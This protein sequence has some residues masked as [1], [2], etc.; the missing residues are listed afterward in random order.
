M[1]HKRN[2]FRRLCRFFLY[3]FII[4]LILSAILVG[5]ARAFTPVLNQYRDK[6]TAFASA[7]LH[8]SVSV[9]RVKGSWHWLEPMIN[10][11]DIVVESPTSSYQKISIQEMDVGINLMRSLFH[12]RLEWGS[13]SIKGSSLLIK[14]DVDEQWQVNGF[15]V[16]YSKSG[17]SLND[18]LNQLFQIDRID[19]NDINLQIQPQSGI[20]I[21][22]NHI[23]LG[24]FNFG[25]RHFLKGN[26]DFV[27]LST[28]P[29]AFILRLEHPSADQWKI[30][31]RHFQIDRLGILMVE[32]NTSF[33]WS[34]QDSQHFMVKGYIDHIALPHLTPLLHLDY[35]FPPVLMDAWNTM[36]PQ[37]NLQDLSWQVIKKDNAPLLYNVKTNIEE[38][39]VNPWKKF[40]GIN[41]L[42]GHVE[43]NQEKGSATLQGQ[44]SI[45]AFPLVFRHPLPVLSWS[46]I[47]N[48]DNQKQGLLLSTSNAQLSTVEGDAKAQLSIFVPYNHD[49]SV[50]NLQAQAHANALSKQAIYGY[51]PT[52]ILSKPLVAWL[53]ADLLGVGDSR[54]SV[55]LKGPLREFPFD[56]GNGAFIIQGDV[57]QAALQLSPGWPTAHHLT[58]HLLFSG[59][60]MSIQASSGEINGA[61]LTKADAEIPY[62]GNQ[63]P[64]V[65]HVSA[66]GQGDASQAL[67][68]LRQSP[69]QHVFQGA[70]KNLEADGPIGLDLSLDLPLSPVNNITPSVKGTLN[71]Q[72]VNL[73]FPSW[74]FIL[75]DLQ[76]TAQFNQQ[77]VTAPKIVGTAFGQA[78]T[79]AISPP[80]ATNQQQT[81]IG[82][83]TV[84][85]LSA[86]QTQYNW[87]FNAMATGTSPITL[88]LEIGKNRA[89]NFFVHSNL[90]GITLNL[91]LS[92]KKAA[93]QSVPTVLKGNYLAPTLQALSFQYGKQLSGQLQPDNRFMLTL[94]LPDIQGSVSLPLQWQPGQML[95][96]QMQRLYIAANAMSSTVSSTT[97]DPTRL[98]KVTYSLA[99]FRY[100]NYVLGQLNGTIMPIQNGA[101]IDTQVSQ[102]AAL[103]GQLKT[104]WLAPA[105]TTMTGSLA[106]SDVAKAL[107]NM[108]L[109]SNIQSQH[110][111]ADFVLNWNGAPYQCHIAALNG[112]INVQIND[113]LITGLNGD[114]NAKLGFG[115]ILTSLSL[116]NLPDRL[117][118]VFSGSVQ[119]GFNFT[120]INASVQVK[121]GIATV[122]NG[123]VVSSLA[124]ISMSGNLNLIDQTYDMIMTVTPHVTSS[125]PVAATLVGGPVVGV[126]VWAANKVLSPVFN[127]ITSYRYSITGSF[128]K[129]V[130]T[131]LN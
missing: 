96:I 64:V 41:H 91:P 111:T 46:G 73:T 115:R 127:A 26:A 33:A 69:Y 90:Q 49:S 45:A 98:P 6:I 122:T 109:P 88:G 112:T 89:V 21:S 99:D 37:G 114:T 77:G 34:Y 40:P 76:G 14:Q 74:S 125:V 9:A 78:L 29:L 129:P 23:H 47:L 43:L 119:N 110:A 85:D 25:Q 56:Q 106:S 18:I 59:R 22:I 79:I 131:K 27:R 5:L 92:L 11:Q 55:I 38:L 101:H 1:A 84:L 17:N 87:P 16:H 116:Q 3:F 36:K 54:A 10:L 32:N 53:D 7:Q 57:N 117:R 121:N 35:P 67:A 107:K 130:L 83:S 28:M 13:V 48:W 62:M 52:G 128:A 126:V 61:S 93:T 44:N 39:A 24:L 58:G 4:F 12:W 95:S 120:K 123:V 102:G 63:K 66:E 68:F 113:G 50:I 104:Q 30:M 105:K 15:D 51:L 31:L 86:L 81:E 2:F 103:S 42:N 108:D 75:H 60:R 8:Q 20:P 100:G 19:L 80:S 70:S 82:I 72:G 65:L 124:G 94:Q 118:S 97:V 71:L